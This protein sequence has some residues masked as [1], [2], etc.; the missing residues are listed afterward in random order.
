MGLIDLFKGKF[1]DP[2]YPGV[3]AGGDVITTS[4]DAMIKWGRKS[5]IWP[6]PFGTACCAI[7][8]M[9]VVVLALRHRALRRR[10]AAL[11]APPVGP[12][13]RGGDDRGQAGPGA[14]DDLRPDAGAEVGDLDGRLRLVGRLLPLVPHDAGHRRDHPRGRLRAR[15]PALAGGA[16]RRAHEDP[17]EDPEGP[18][19]EGAAGCPPPRRLR[20]R[21]HRPPR[22][23]RRT[24][25]GTTPQR[26]AEGQ[27]PRGRLELRVIQENAK[28]EHHG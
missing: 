15:L 12:D 14:Q 1:V 13:V 4:L 9:A 28:E 5:S 24:G 25:R 20:G 2:T 8:F 27:A 17:G 16:P 22:P 11:L 7:E 23:P 6:L 18:A 21:G 3:H 26:H 19:G 10:G